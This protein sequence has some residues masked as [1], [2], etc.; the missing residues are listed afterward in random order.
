MYGKRR[1]AK[2]LPPSGPGRQS[3]GTARV[4]A[5]WCCISVRL[6]GLG[7]V[8]RDPPD[9][10]RSL[11]RWCSLKA[12]PLA[13]CFFQATLPA[14]LGQRGILAVVLA[15]LDPPGGDPDDELAE[16]HG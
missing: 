14:Q 16:P 12:F 11:V 10:L 5:I 3:R 4:L 2:T 1:E 15:V 7:S 9:D 8:S 13:L 6:P